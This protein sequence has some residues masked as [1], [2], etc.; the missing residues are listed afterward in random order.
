MS[1]SIIDFQKAYKRARQAGNSSFIF[2]G[3]RFLTNQALET[4]MEGKRL[5]PKPYPRTKK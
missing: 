2:E 1:D 3:K 4:I 5:V